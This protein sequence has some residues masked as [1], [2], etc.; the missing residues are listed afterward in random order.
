MA[1]LLLVLDVLCVWTLLVGVSAESR[2]K[3]SSES[4]SGDVGFIF[5][6]K[7]FIII[8]FL[9]TE[10]PILQQKNFF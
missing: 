1:A 4:G 3:Y 5:P 9:S 6:S 2:S 10:I 8:T 7:Q